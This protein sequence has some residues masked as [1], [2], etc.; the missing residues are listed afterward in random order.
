VFGCTAYTL[1]PKESRKKLD[2]KSKP[3]IFLGYCEYSKGYKL[4]APSCP[5]K[6]IK[7][8]HVVFVEDCFNSEN[9]QQKIVPSSQLEPP[10]MSVGQLLSPEGGDAQSVISEE[11]T[12][13]LECENEPVES[14][15]DGDTDVEQR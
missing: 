9:R 2:A 12:M 15:T 7:A 5:K 11:L 13:E 6:Q 8:R 1:I 14:D 4:A 10:A 3:Y